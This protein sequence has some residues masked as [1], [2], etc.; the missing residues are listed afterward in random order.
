MN[1]IIICWIIIIVLGTASGIAYYET[2][3]AKQRQLALLAAMNENDLLKQ[4]L[5]NSSQ[6]A[7]RL[8]LQLDRLQ[9]TQLAHK[10][11]KVSPDPDAGPGPGDSKLRK[12]QTDLANGTIEF[13]SLANVGQS[14]PRA[15]LET[16]QD[17]G[18]PAPTRHRRGAAYRL[19]Q[20]GNVEACKSPIT[21]RKPDLLL[22]SSRG[23]RCSVGTPLWT[24]LNQGRAAFAAG[25]SQ[26][27]VRRC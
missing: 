20:T 23:L 9:A 25:L 26:A 11:N 2:Q 14:T 27:G 21:S 13:R 12:I 7:E 19:Y 22:L 24:A 18:V 8:R 6:Q 1:K 10:S 16:L 5:R 15:G 4:K 3:A 17:S